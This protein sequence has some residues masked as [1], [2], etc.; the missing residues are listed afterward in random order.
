MTIAS[1][2]DKSESTGLRDCESTKKNKTPDFSG[3]FCC[4][5]QDSGLLAFPSA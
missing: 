3:V 4:Q 5:L 2:M 1:L